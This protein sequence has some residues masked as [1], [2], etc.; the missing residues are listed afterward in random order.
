[1]R[2]DELKGREGL[3]SPLSRRGRG[4]GFAGYDGGHSERRVQDEVLHHYKALAA[5]LKTESDKGMWQ[6]F[7]LGGLERN[8]KDLESYLPS[9]LKQNLLGHFSVDLLTEPLEQVRAKAGRLMQQSLD[10]RRRDMLSQV[11]SRAKSNQRGVTGLR[12]VLSAL[13][14]G[15]VQSLVLGEHYS[16]PA[17]ECGHCGHLD[18]RRMPQCPVCGQTTREL[19]DVC[20]AILPIA[21]RRDIE[22]LYVKDDPGLDQVGNIGALLRYRSEHTRGA[23]AAS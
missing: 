15:E 22:V 6:K 3:F 19:Q 16:A 1:L 11:L 4:D 23:R 12:R 9:T 14:M 7:V 18:S 21:I 2:L 13:E 8:W 5:R 20:E 10:L 17:V